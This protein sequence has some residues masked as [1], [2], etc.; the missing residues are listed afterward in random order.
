MSK[1]L[2]FR[3]D[4]PFYLE[5]RLSSKLGFYLQKKVFKE[6]MLFVK[7][8][9]L[10]VNDTRTSYVVLSQTGDENDVVSVYRMG[11]LNRRCDNI[12]S[13]FTDP[14]K[15]IGPLRQRLHNMAQSLKPSERKYINS[16]MDEHFPAD[17]VY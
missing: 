2:K 17:G 5:C 8:D 3:H 10:K 15:A 9:G 12:V 11:E 16:Y 6:H 1:T 14:Y 7:P 13:F 4:L